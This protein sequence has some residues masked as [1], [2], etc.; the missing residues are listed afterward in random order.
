MS[1][2]KNKK[3]LWS[4]INSIYFSWRTC[5]FQRIA[6]HWPEGVKLWGGYE[7]QQTSS[8][9]AHTHS[10]IGEEEINRTNIRLAEKPW[11]A[12]RLHPARTGRRRRRERGRPRRGLQQ[13][14][15]RTG[16]G[17]CAASPCPWPPW[18]TPC[19]RCFTSPVAPLAM[20]VNSKFCSIFLSRS[21]LLDHTIRPL[22][23][24][25]NSKLCSIFIKSR[26]ALFMKI[27]IVT[28]KDTII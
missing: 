24:L 8:K 28:L 19:R 10:V 26:S 15:R 9:N 4:H 2:N 12:H 18:A 13:T 7:S 11:K 17:R 16:D 1:I 3:I 5:M 23:M 14:A 6:A 25:V 20:L 27:W 22:T 21:I